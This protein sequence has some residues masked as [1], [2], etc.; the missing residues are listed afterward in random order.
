[1]ECRFA[2][3]RFVSRYIHSADNDFDTWNVRWRPGH[4]EVVGRPSPNNPN[5]FHSFKWYT[6]NGN[7]SLRVGPAN[8]KLPRHLSRHP[9]PIVLRDVKFLPADSRSDWKPIEEGS[10]IEVALSV[11]YLDGSWTGGAANSGHYLNIA[12]R[13]LRSGPS[14]NVGYAFFE[15]D[16]DEPCKSSTTTWESENIILSSDVTGIRE[17]FMYVFHGMLTDYLHQSSSYFVRRSLSSN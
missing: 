6:H 14:L 9:T 10:D 15:V 1:M 13:S 17:L 12:M 5:L 4:S 3:L 11:T 16:S 2:F 8:N 7:Y